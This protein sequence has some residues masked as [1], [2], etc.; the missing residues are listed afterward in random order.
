MRKTINRPK[1][2]YNERDLEDGELSF[3]DYCNKF[4]EGGL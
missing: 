2:Q 3:T 1:T 4:T